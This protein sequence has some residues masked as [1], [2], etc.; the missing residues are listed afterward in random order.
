MVIHMSDTIKRISLRFNLQEQKS[1]KAWNALHNL[2]EVDYNI[3]QEFIIDAILKYYEWLHERTEPYNRAEFEERIKELMRE[4]IA[5]SLLPDKRSMDH[6]SENKSVKSRKRKA[7]PDIKE[8]FVIDDT[9][10]NQAM[11]FLSTL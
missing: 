4:V 1:L 8:E 6:K 10:M 5:E 9:A 7:V 2:R 11:D 3:I